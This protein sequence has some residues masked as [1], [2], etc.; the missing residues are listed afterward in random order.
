MTT[1]ADEI[2]THLRPLVGLKLSIARRAA[3]LRIFQFGP[4]RK[5]EQGSIGDYALHIQCPWRIEGPQGIVTGRSDL[6]E[7]ADASPEIDWKNW[8]YDRDEN[9][10]DKCVGGWLGSYDPQTRSFV[11]ESD[12][13]VVEAVQADIYGGAMIILSGSYRLVLFPAGT[14][15]E[16]WRIF[17]PG[18]DEPHF[19]ISGGRIENRNIRAA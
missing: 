2:I 7:P 18:T 8:N 5:V 12:Q 9:L 13:L 15:G 19:V 1:R 4:I 10:Q 6:W 16:D 17:Q 11:N 14:R 3:D